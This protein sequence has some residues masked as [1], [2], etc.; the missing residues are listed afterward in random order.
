MLFVLQGGRGGG[1]EY[2]PQVFLHVRVCA[3]A[4][5]FAVCARA[6][7]R[8][9]ACAC[10]HVRLRA[11]TCECELAG[12]LRLDQRRGAPA[13][14]LVRALWRVKARSVPS[15]PSL[16]PFEPLMPSAS[17]VRAYVRAS[18][19]RACVPRAGMVTS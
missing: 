13:S 4:C 12:R 19:V 9:R 2:D 14:P 6:C 11:C 15:C 18:T 1:G 5:A 3:R 17:T 16:V 7:A 10:V 8:L